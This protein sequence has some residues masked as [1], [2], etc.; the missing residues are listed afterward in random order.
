VVAASERGEA[1]EADAMQAA[2]ML[3]SQRAA[4]DVLCCVCGVS[5]KPNKVNT[6]AQCLQSSHD[7]TSEFAKQ[8]VLLRCKACERFQKATQ[9]WIYCALESKPL[10]ALCLKKIK[11]LQKVSLVDATFIWTEEH[12]KRI[13]LKLTVQK[14]VAPQVVLQQQCT[15]EFTIQNKMCEDCHM[16]EASLTWDSVAQVR[17]KVTHKRT[18]LFLEQLILKHGE[19][20]RTIKVE[21]QPDGIDFY[22]SAKNDAVRFIDFLET[23]IPLRYKTSKKILTQDTKSN[24]ATF[25]NTFSVEIVPLCKD[26]LVCLPLAVARKSGNIS[27]IALVSNVTNVIRFLDPITCQVADLS[28]ERF[29]RTPFRAILDSRRLVSFTV[30]D[31]QLHDSAEEKARLREEAKRAAAAFA[32]APLDDM[33]VGKKRRR[34]GKAATTLLTHAGVNVSPNHG[35]ATVEVARDDDFGVNDRRFQVLSHLGF[36]LKPG[37][38]VLGYDL[39]TAN[40]NDNDV[41]ELRSGKSMPEVILVRKHYPRFRKLNKER[42]WKLK[43]LVVGGDKPGVAHSRDDG[44]DAE[45]LERDRELF[46]RDI[47]ED[48]EMRSRINVYKNSKD[49][50]ARPAAAMAAGDES[51]VEEDAPTIGVEHLLD[52]LAL[53]QD[54]D[55]EDDDESGDDDE[56]DPDL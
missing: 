42:D 55:E 54:Q 39:T 27:Q 48:E 18:F 14:E 29:W 49:G 11:G 7:V 36:V 17:Q 46:F 56:E 43:S 24:F 30:L 52:E 20:A 23:V 19:D 6:C 25:N 22:F 21:A 41:E 13:R 12:S 37:D 1:G 35:L 31:V 16:Q 9:G 50:V 4:P 40:L 8:A 15:V 53:S 2:A 3:P 33:P 38:S 28:G 10:L 34:K 51:D 47:E 26:D 44:K 32:G 45:E 5:M